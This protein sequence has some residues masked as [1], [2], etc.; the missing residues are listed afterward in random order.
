MTR[1]DI[2][3]LME[4][5]DGR[6]KMKEIFNGLAENNSGGVEIVTREMGPDELN[7]EEFVQYCYHL[8][9]KHFNA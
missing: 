3:S 8:F 9:D 6:F 5:P 1:A 4:A 2:L 7:G